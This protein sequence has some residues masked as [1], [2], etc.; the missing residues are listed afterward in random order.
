MGSSSIFDVVCVPLNP[1]SDNVANG[2]RA[3]PIETPI[4]CGTSLSPPSANSMA[5]SQ[6]GAFAI[7]RD[8]SI[9]SKTDRYAPKSHPTEK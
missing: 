3:L 4:I 1:R 7:D 5:N 2:I 6:S 8:V 9:E